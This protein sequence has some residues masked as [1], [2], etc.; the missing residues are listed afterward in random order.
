MIDKF[1]I[2]AN[3]VRLFGKPGPPF[4]SRLS[5]F[6]RIIFSNLSSKNFISSHTTKLHP[7]SSAVVR[8]YILTQAYCNDYHTDATDL[9]GASTAIMSE[10]DQVVFWGNHE[11][12]HQLNLYLT[13]NL[14]AEEELTK[15]RL[16][17]VSLY[18]H[19]TFDSNGCLEIGRTGS[20]CKQLDSMLPTAWL[21]QN[22]CY[23][24]ELPSQP[25]WKILATPRN[26]KT[27]KNIRGGAAIHRIHSRILKSTFWGLA[28]W[29]IMQGG[30][31][32]LLDYREI[33]LQEDI[34]K[35][36]EE[37]A[38]FLYSNTSSTLLLE[39]STYN[40]V[41]FKI[42]QLTFTKAAIQPLY[43]LHGSN[44]LSL[45]AF[46]PCFINLS[47]NDNGLTLTKAIDSEL[48]LT[49]ASSI[50]ALPLVQDSISQ[51]EILEKNGFVLT[52]ISIRKIKFDNLQ[53]VGLWS[54]INSDIILALPYYFDFIHAN[55]EDLKLVNVLK[56]ITTML[57]EQRRL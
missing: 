39:L 12:I 9:D 38:V 27:S 28:P 25:Y 30:Y 4:V 43:V 55:N 50:V 22:L 17:T 1:N 8:N 15:L 42:N 29:Y 51:Q 31:L 46:N 7:R 11:D 52:A 21:L 6:K 13:N 56:Q 44:N 14:V 18:L 20:T 37:T 16:G 49:S 10:Q 54:R 47:H 33:Y 36:L 53:P 23:G 3:T 5:E 45:Q 32:E 41:N 19:D 48:S 34:I 24:N 35:K 57:I 26:R 40:K 2:H